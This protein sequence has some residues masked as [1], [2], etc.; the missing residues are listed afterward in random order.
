MSH[1]RL[2]KII[3][4]PTLLSRRKAD[5][6]IKQGRLKMNGREAIFGE[7]A[8]PNSDHILVEWKGLHKKL[9]HKVF[10]LNKPYGVISSCQDNHGRKTSL[11]FIPS[12]LR[13]GIYTAEGLDFDSRGVILL[14]NNGDLS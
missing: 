13:C 7:K 11:S 2:K 1:N 6:L 8:D 4:G 9:N 5:I 10:I 14:T 12:H 3:S